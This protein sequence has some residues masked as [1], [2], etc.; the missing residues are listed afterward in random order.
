MLNMRKQFIMLN[1]RKSFFVLVIEG[2]S[3]QV[4]EKQLPTR[5]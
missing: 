1:M 2:N 3:E 4:P 5:V